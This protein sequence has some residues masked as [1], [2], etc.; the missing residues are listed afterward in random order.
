MHEWTVAGALIETDE[1]ILLV[2][3]LRHGGHEDWS[4]PGGVIDAEDPSILEGLAREVEEE[5]G[6]RVSSW[7][8]PLYEVNAYAL[9]LGWHMRCEVY[10]AVSFEGHLEID[11]PDGI[12][13]EAAFVPPHELDERLSTGHPWVREPLIEWLLHRWEPGC[14]RGFH[15]EVRGT[16]LGEMRVVRQ[17]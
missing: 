10:L 16:R 8:E 15:Y 3:N 7:S 6:L 17:S 12:V 11:D 4:T 14:G 13:V 2:R 1:G 9:D 5:T